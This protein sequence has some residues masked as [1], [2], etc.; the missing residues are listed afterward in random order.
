MPAELN[1]WSHD[2]V[3]IDGNT[4]Q[5]YGERTTLFDDINEDG[6]RVR[7]WIFGSTRTPMTVAAGQGV[8]SIV[9]T[10][11]TSLVESESPSTAR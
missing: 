5:N 6:S 3:I 1:H 4:T 7:L 2:H 10:L 8:S 9:N 11:D